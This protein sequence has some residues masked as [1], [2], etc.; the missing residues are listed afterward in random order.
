[1]PQE[2]GRKIKLPEV[3]KAGNTVLTHSKHSVNE[4]LVADSRCLLHSNTC[5]F[6]LSLEERFALGD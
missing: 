2:S 4:R 3:H 5:S 1:M 6:P